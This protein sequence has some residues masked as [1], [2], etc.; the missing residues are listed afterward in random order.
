MTE[1]ISKKRVTAVLFLL[2]IFLYAG[3]NAKKELPILKETLETSIEEGDD[4]A[5]LIASVDTSI[6]ENV[7]YRYNF[8]DA[9]GLIQKFLDK[10]K[11]T[12]LKWSKI[13]K[14][15]YIIPTLPKSRTIRKICPRA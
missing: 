2:F 1:L 7:K 4:P 12:I 9:Y 11:K 15:N 8:I 10:M 5:E 6:N 14:E 3:I 13:R